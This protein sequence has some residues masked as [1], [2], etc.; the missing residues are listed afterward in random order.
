M[1]TASIN[2]IKDDYSDEHRHVFRFHVKLWDS[3]AAQVVQLALKQKNINVNASDILP[4]PMQM[5]RLGIGPDVTT[6]IQHSRHWRSH[7]DQPNT[8]MFE[9]YTH[10]EHFC[11]K[12]VRLN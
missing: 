9:L 10:H 3:T 11:E 7:Q 4:L 8:I 12:M 6:Q 1:D 5:V 2:C